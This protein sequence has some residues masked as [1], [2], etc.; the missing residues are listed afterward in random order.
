MMM[1]EREGKGGE[2]WGE[3]EGEGGDSARIIAILV[4]IKLCHTPL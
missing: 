2:G 1:V 4:C 3:G